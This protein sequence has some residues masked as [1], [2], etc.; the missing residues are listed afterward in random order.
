M[1]TQSYPHHIPSI[2]YTDPSTKLQTLDLWFP[3]PLSESSPQNTIWIVYAHGGAWRDPTQTSTCILPTLKNLFGTSSPSKALDRIAGIASLNYRLSPYPSHPTDPSKPDDPDRNVKHP[4]HVQDVARAMNWL[5]KEYG[6]GRDS[7]KYEWVGIGHSCGAT[8]LLQLLSSIGLDRTQSLQAQ[9]L[10][11]GDIPT[12]SQTPQP[13]TH[14]NSK[15]EVV[16]LEVK[17]PKAL[18][19]LEGVYDIPLFLQNHSIEKV[20]EETSQVY[21]DIIVGAFGQEKESEF[22]NESVWEDVSP[23]QSWYGEE[24]WREGSSVLL[25]HSDEDELVEG[26][27][28]E[29]MVGCLRECGWREETDWNEA[30]VV[31]VRKL[32]GKHD[33][34]W[35]DGTQIKGLIEELVEQLFGD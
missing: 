29:S 35:E 11:G 19:L 2:P 26:G 24:V 31:E 28:V 12:S 1:S 5:G 10:V 17:G 15:S 30:R 6:V 9:K 3:R 22:G 21:R 23:S 25:C 27:Q 7:T 33:W 32:K 13:D 18:V 34:I 8:L 4:D 16:S 14:P 20:G